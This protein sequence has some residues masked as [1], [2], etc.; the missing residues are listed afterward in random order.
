MNIS[1][2]AKSLLIISV[3]LF[4]TVIVYS[5]SLNNGFTHW[6]EEQ[7][8]LKNPDVRSLSFEGIERIFNSTVFSTYSPLTV[9]F[10]S[11]EY[12]FFGGNP[13]IYHFVNLLLHLGVVCFVYLLGLRLGLGFWACSLATLIF[14]IHPIHVESVCWIVERKDVLYAFFYLACVCAYLKYIDEN[15]RWF[16]WLALV[17]CLLSILSKAMALSLPLIFLVCQWVKGQ[18]ISCKSLGDKIPFFLIVISIAAITYL[19]NARIV[20]MI[21]INAFSIWIWTFIFYIRKFLFPIELLPLYQLPQPVTLLNPEYLISLLAFGVMVTL[22]F[23]LRNNKWFIFSFL[24]YF[25][26]IFFILRFDGKVDVS[27]VA[28]R[29]MYLPCLGFCFLLGKVIKERLNSLN[30]KRFFGRMF[31]IAV[32]LVFGMGLA[33]KTFRQCDVWQDAFSLWEYQI[34]KTPQ[35][36]R[37][38]DNLGAAYLRAGQLDM[39]LVQLNKAM[40]LDPQSPTS[41]NNVGLVYIAKKNFPKAISSFQAGINLNPLLDSIIYNNLGAA[42]KNN[43][44]LA[45]ASAAFS[46]SIELDPKTLEARL[47]LA[48]IKIAEDK[49]L[50]AE[51]LYFQNLVVS[52]KDDQTRFDLVNFYLKS[53]DFH[54]AQSVADKMIQDAFSAEIM[55]QLGAIF[56]TGN[57]SLRAR[58][59]YQRALKVNPRYKLAYEQLGKLLG[60]YEKFQEAIEVWQIGLRFYPSDPV[61]LDLITQAKAL[62]K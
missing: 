3:I 8:L 49:N 32:L 18:K 56:Y 5:P 58:A 24:F 61:L 21:S 62:S 55:T 50:E 48:Q 42:F 17:F 19:L 12:H 54:K 60:N 11:L 40:T 43:G 13:F 26:S 2:R 30:V 35:E 6:D 9:L 10:F 16:Y 59:C 23:Y 53:K 44:Q 57:D 27:I 39:A 28:D 14:A 4:I 15:N 33:V 31:F 46:R 34:K 38:Y 37:A 1:R 52:P 25:L 20:Q 51:K 29:F 45:Q 7:Y 47:G 41:F 22:V 36:V